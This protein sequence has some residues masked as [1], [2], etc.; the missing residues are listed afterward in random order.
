MGEEKSVGQ[1]QGVVPTQ[2]SLVG[3]GPRASSLRAEWES[4]MNRRYERNKWDG[5]GKTRWTTTGGVSLHNG[6]L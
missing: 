1:P 3:D 6:A 5:K 2:W 4:F